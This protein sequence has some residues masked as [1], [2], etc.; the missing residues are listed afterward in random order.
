MTSGAMSAATTAVRSREA[1][2]T[3]DATWSGARVAGVSCSLATVSRA[4]RL[5]GERNCPRRREREAQA[6]EDVGR[7]GKR[8]GQTSAAES[9]PGDHAACEPHCY[10]YPMNYPANVER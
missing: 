1:S 9:A 6:G 8:R 10:E 2:I 4:D 5:R 3:P 7:G